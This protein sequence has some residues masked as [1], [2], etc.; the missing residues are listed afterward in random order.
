MAIDNIDLATANKMIETAIA[1]ARRHGHQPLT[2]CVVDKGGHMISAQREDNSSTFRFEIAFG[3]AWTCIALGHSTNFVEKIMSKNRPHFVDSLAAA[4][5]GKF[6]PALG[7]VLVRDR[8]TGK[9]VGAVGATGDSGEN[10]E[11]VAIE[12]IELCGF[13]ADLS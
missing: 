8:E 4:S 5:G 13:T 10:D 12:A 9:I 1:I 3:K 7:G 2:F 11:K 6:I